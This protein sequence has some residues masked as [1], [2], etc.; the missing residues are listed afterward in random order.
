MCKKF[1]IFLNR[2]GHLDNQKNKIEVELNG[3]SGYEIKHSK[4][5]DDEIT[6]IGPGTKAGEYLR[7]YLGTFGRFSY[8]KL[9]VFQG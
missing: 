8:Y 3:F 6:R 4:E 2:L 7:R 1:T 5:V 9:K